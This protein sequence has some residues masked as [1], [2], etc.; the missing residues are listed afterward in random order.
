[1]NSARLDQLESKHDPEVDRSWQLR[2]SSAHCDQELA[3]RR[4]G[5]GEGGGGK[6]LRAITWQVG[7]KE[8]K[9]TFRTFTTKIVHPLHPSPSPFPATFQPRRHAQCGRRVGQHLVLRH[10]Q[11]KAAVPQQLR[12]HR[13]HLDHGQAFAQ[14]L[15]GTRME[16]RILIGILAPKTR[17][18]KKNMQKR[19]DWY[20]HHCGNP[21]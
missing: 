2:S 7:K 1:M 10:G 3:M 11:A 19:L 5:G 4:G 9:K 12:Q 20:P 21:R 8:I 6:R 16:D 14:A 15:A 13:L 17:G 18:G